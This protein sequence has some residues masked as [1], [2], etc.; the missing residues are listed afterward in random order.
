MGRSKYER[1]RGRGESAVEVA[2]VRKRDKRGVQVSVRAPKV[3]PPDL[4]Y[5][6]SLFPGREG[7]A[8]R[9]EAGFPLGVYWLRG[10]LTREQFETGQRWAVHRANADRFLGLP[11]RTP[12]NA[13]LR[14]PTGVKRLDPYYNPIGRRNRGCRAIYGL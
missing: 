9:Q 6:K 2:G 13:D 8:W 5:R 4:S 10:D 11:A 7:L 14:H 1:R 12:R 3:P